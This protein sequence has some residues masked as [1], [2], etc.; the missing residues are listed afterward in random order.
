[1]RTYLRLHDCVSS[2]H[3]TSI[4][5]NTPREFFT[6]SLLTVEGAKVEISLDANTAREM[7][8][9]MTRALDTGEYVL[10]TDLWSE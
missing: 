9:A 7:A 2:I 10:V 6:V 4:A 1:M 3:A 5:R 8:N